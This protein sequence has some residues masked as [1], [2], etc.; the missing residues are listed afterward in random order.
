MRRSAV[1]VSGREA[2]LPAGGG[3]P[4]THCH[5]RSDAAGGSFDSLGVDESEGG[6]YCESKSNKG[7]KVTH[8]SFIHST[9]QPDLHH[10]VPDG[11]RSLF[12]VDWNI[13]V[14][15]RL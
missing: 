7:D 15:P 5:F 10:I 13:T 8:D 1:S 4:E 9:C 14:T 6:S 12:L 2:C 11:L 3:Q